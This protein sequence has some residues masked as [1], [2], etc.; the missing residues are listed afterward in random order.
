V[1][2]RPVQ[3]HQT[4]WFS[5]YIWF[6]SKLCFCPAV[7][8]THFYELLGYISKS[9]N[10]LHSLNMKN[11]CISLISCQGFITRRCWSLPSSGNCRTILFLCLL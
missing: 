7:F 11:L 9:G 3:D 1:A 4:R 8:T 10:C 2:A 6:Y 5:S